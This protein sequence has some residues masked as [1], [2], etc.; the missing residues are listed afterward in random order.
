[1]LKRKILTLLLATGVLA[2]IFTPS[3]KATASFGIYGY[4][5]KIQYEYGETGELKI[6]IIN[7]GTD[8]LILHNITIRY[9]WNDILPWEGNDTMK[10][11]DEAISVKA[12]RTFS[13]EFKVPDDRGV[14]SSPLSYSSIE[15]AVVTDK[16]DDTEH[17]PLIIT[18][19]PV[20]MEVQ[21]MD[22]LVT[23][24]TVQIIIAII[25]AIIIAA[26]VFLSGRKPGVTWQKEE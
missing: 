17:I 12:N 8:P 26:A 22:N 11:I 25:A 13:F 1:M 16:V 23:L 5:D 14:L 6:W 21:D 20:N 4:T 2:L 19:P 7:D 24:I 9:P 15:V 18:N 10:E 3:V